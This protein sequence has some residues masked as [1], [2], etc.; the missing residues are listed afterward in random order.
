MAYTANESIMGRNKY[1]LGFQG[2]V[3]TYHWVKAGSVAHSAATIAVTEF[4]PDWTVV[5]D[6]SDFDHSTV[7]CKSHQPVSAYEGA[8]LAGT[9]GSAFKLFLQNYNPPQLGFVRVHVEDLTPYPHI[10][11]PGQGQTITSL[12]WVGR[13]HGTFKLGNVANS[14]GN[15]SVSGFDL[16]TT[17]FLYCDGHVENKSI[18]DTLKPWEWGDQIYSLDRGT[19]INTK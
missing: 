18:V 5:N 6:V 13:N 16:R 2:C 17:N 15:G 9:P 8:G 14:K 12:D 11:T 7:V 1:V 19:D 3:R 4:N 10:G